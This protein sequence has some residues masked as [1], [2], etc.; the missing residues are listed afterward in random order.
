MSR[1]AA[2]PKSVSIVK[3]W[4]FVGTRRVES[5]AWDSDF[6]STNLAGYDVACGLAEDGGELQPRESGP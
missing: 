3:V 2:E 1:T 5:V 6:S 4:V